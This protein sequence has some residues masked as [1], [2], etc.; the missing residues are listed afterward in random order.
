LAAGDFGKGVKGLAE[1]FA[2]KVAAEL[3]LKAVD[4]ALDAVVSSD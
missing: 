1:V 3:H 2:E 4:D